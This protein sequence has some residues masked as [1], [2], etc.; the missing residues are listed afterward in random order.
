MN[1]TVTPSLLSSVLMA[2]Q[3]AE[4]Q[5]IATDL[6]DSIGQSLSALSY[7]I[8]AALDGTRKGNAAMVG[9]ML[10]KLAAQVRES[11]EELRRIAMDLK[12]PML[13]DIGLIATLSWFFREFRSLHPGLALN[14]DIDIEECDVQPELRTNIFRVVQEAVNN[15][16]KHA[17]A[18]EIRVRLQRAE[19]EVQLE[20]VDD[21]AGFVVDEAGHMAEANSGMGLQGMCDRA[22]SCGGRFCLVSVPGQGTRVFVA[23]PAPLH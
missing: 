15:V 3:E 16:V 20:V 12:P 14:S 22:E 23:W 6:H 19:R 11:I 17:G 21:G 5:R 10:E 2:M 4:R 9:T 13:D 7:G 1:M 8:D 18:N